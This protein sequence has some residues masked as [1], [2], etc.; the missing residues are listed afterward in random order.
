MEASKF[1]FQNDERWKN[2]QITETRP[3]TLGSHG[4]LI[5]SLTNAY[6]D[7]NREHAECESC[8]LPY[9]GKPQHDG[10][11]SYTPDMMLGLLKQHKAINEDAMVVWKPAEEVLNAEIEPFCKAPDPYFAYQIVQYV[12]FGYMHFSNVIKI[13]D[14]G[15][16][17]VYDV[18][19]GACKELLPNQVRRW[20]NVRFIQ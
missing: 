6:N 17:L 5:T 4:C 3:Y 19:S 15:N 13:M 2:I 20:I 11:V 1:F 8:Y 12:N 9:T 10:S 18:Y 7:Y 14:N 16:I